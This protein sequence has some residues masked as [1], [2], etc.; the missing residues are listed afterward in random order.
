MLRIYTCFILNC[1]KEWSYERARYYEVHKWTDIWLD[2][3]DT[4]EKLKLF[5]CVNYTAQNVE[6]TLVLVLV[7]TDTVD[8]LHG[9]CQEPN[10]V[11]FQIL[12]R[13]LFNINL[14]DLHIRCKECKVY[15]NKMPTC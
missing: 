5:T 1:M 15:L 10:K 3:T 7:L 8:S 6:N 2:S 12:L 4:S 13:F 11:I 14:W 9:Y